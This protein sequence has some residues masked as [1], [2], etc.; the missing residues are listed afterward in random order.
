MYDIL[1]TLSMIGIMVC[2]IL[3][4]IEG[5][6]KDRYIKALEKQIPR[7]GSGVLRDVTIIGKNFK[8]IHFGEPHTDKPYVM[9]RGLRLAATPDAEILASPYV[10]LVLDDCIIYD[11]PKEEKTK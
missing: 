6:K 9:L 5:R 11:E 4:F 1:F 3:I 7:S 2:Q 8:H 10:D